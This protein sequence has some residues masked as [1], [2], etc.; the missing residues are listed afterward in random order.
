MK[1]SGKDKTASSRRNERHG[2]SSNVVSA[3]D[4]DEL[5]RHYKFVLPEKGGETEGSRSSSTW[6]DR[7]VQ[8]YHSHLYK[9]Y[10]IVD[11]SVPA[12]IGLRF[13]TKTE[14]VAGKGVETCG[15]K[16]CPSYKNPDLFSQGA[17]GRH[18]ARRQ[19]NDKDGVGR[20]LCD[21]EVPFQYVEQSERKVRI[22]THC[23]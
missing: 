20:G 8:H 19:D 10:A 2:P 13:R 15:N 14:V 4:H 12:R 1:R 21:Y 16:H 11:L 7:M 17:R 18:L 3:V 23:S 22:M 9:E 6:Q 5:R